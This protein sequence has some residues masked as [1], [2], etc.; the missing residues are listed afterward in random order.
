MP[1]NFIPNDPLATGSV[2]M[3]NR[4]P[5]ANRKS[6]QAGFTFVAASPAAL[7]DPG[8]ADFLFW[9]S[10][11]AALAAIQMWETLNGPLKQWGA[12]TANPDK[13]ELLPDAGD[14]LNAFYDRQ[15]L[16]FFHHTVESETF[17]SGAS[18]DVVSHESVHAF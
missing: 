3:R 18:T 12:K 6:G 17:F 14:D 16:S 15:S 11:E 1:I 13:L 9:Q 2:P 4:E 8:T 7:F 10:R 5:L